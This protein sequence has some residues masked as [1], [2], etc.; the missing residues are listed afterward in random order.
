[1]TIEEKVEQI[2]R[3]SSAPIQLTKRS[4]VKIL[5]PVLKIAMQRNAVETASS[6]GP[7]LSAGDILENSSYDDEKIEWSISQTPT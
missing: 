6:C 2:M 3:T 5:N 4:L 1:M 7:L